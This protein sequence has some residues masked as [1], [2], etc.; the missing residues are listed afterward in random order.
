M[1]NEIRSI[2]SGFINVIDETLA[3]DRVQRV[4]EVAIPILTLN[5]YFDKW[6]TI[7]SSFFKARTLACELWSKGKSNLDLL[8]MSRCALYII[9]A[10]FLLS[11][12]RHRIQAFLISRLA[13]M[14]ILYGQANTSPQ[15]TGAVKGLAYMSTKLASVRYG[16]V[17]WTV[18]HYLV[19]IAN[20][21]H[22]AK[23]QRA[24]GKKVPSLVHLGVAGYHGN[25]LLPTLV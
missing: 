8:D 23:Q 25:R 16:R 18:T 5:D 17:E 10:G 13:L 4:G 9:S 2:S 20:N 3:D 15:K 12:Y 24:K 1:L 21:V 19:K 7:S 6:Y 22:S 14:A 11:S